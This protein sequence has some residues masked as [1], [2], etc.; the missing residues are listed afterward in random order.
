MV[1][2][3]IIFV[4]IGIYLAKYQDSS[5]LTGLVVGIIIGHTLDMILQT[6]LGRLK[7]TKYIQKQNNDYYSNVFLNSVFHLLGKLSA[8]DGVINKE[9]LQY[10]EK[11]C[12][13]N[14]KFKR[15]AKKEALK[16]FHSAFRS[17][18]SFQ[19]DAAQFYEIH[20]AQ[21]QSLENMLIFLFNLAAADGEIVSAEERLLDTAAQLFNIPLDNYLQLKFHY[22]PHL[23]AQ[24]QKQSEQNAKQES[25]EQNHQP[26]PASTPIDDYYKVL[27]CNKTD[28]ASK[29]KQQYRKLVSDYHPDKIV[30]KNLPEDFIKFANEKFKS[31]QEAYQAV[32]V[33]KGFN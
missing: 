20:K 18:S 30:A 25:K 24:Y 6:K 3:K 8:V 7:A 29:I 28:P 15:A 31:I 32:K 17:P 12:N 27:G 2:F 4:Y 22:L 21:P 13:E 10:V 1:I 11:L 9:E 5:V 33:E 19:Y 16:I 26:P 14:L 23:E